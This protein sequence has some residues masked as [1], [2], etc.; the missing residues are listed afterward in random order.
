MP[1]TQLSPQRLF[2][3]KLDERG[4]FPRKYRSTHSGYRN[5]PTEH[6]LASHGPKIVDTVKRNHPSELRLMMEVGL[7]PNAC[8][9]NGES[10]LHMV[11]RRDRVD[12]FHVLLAFDVDLQQCDDHGRTVMHDACWVSNPSS[13]E[14][15]KCLLQKDPNLLF[16]YDERGMHPLEYGTFF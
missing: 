12:L 3:R 7:S 5:R 2:H 13:F 14:I 1:V 8:N 6:Q 15:A 16:M 9:E 4:Y 11:C 10:L